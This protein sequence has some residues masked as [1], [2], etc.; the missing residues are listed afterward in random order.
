MKQKKEKN[1]KKI[2]LSLEGSSGDFSLSV[3]AVS[4]AKVFMLTKEEIYP[5]KNY[6]ISEYLIPALDSI[7][8][9]TGLKKEEITALI[10]TTG[11]GA[12]TAIRIVL[13]SVLAI[14]LG[15]KTPIYSLD[16]L[17]TSA[18]AALYS[19]KI[20][21]KQMIRVALKAYKGE[22]YTSDFSQN[23]LLTEKPTK[24][25]IQTPEEFIK[26]IKKE[27]FLVGSGISWLQEN[28]D[29][30]IAKKQNFITKNYLLSSN[31]ARYLLNRPSLSKYQNQKPTFL[32]KS[33]A[34][35]NYSS[36]EL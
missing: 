15:L 11:P 20:Q 6:T 10:T 28:Q 5:S 24:P 21:E 23:C 26:K 25:K 17:K 36:K 35:I 18:L 12:F 29:W 33:E 3:F 31:L 27:D 16:S 13:S 32:R 22:L 30:K 34:E 1:K 19:K 9:K 4:Q 8:K 7:L 14:G 2:F